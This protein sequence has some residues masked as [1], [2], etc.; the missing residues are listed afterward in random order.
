MP[1]TDYMPILTTF[2]GK[3]HPFFQRKKLRV[4]RLAYLPKVTVEVG[5][6]RFKPNYWPLKPVLS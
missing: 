3:R 4:E 2:G 1:S 5:K 6:P